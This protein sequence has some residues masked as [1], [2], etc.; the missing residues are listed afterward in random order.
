MNPR[1]GQQIV[2]LE[3]SWGSLILNIAY[4]AKKKKKKAENPLTWSLFSSNYA[5]L[6]NTFTALQNSHITSFT[7]KKTLLHTCNHPYISLKL[8][9]W[10]T[11]GGYSKCKSSSAN[12]L[13]L[14]FAQILSSQMWGPCAQK[15]W[16]FPTAS[17]IPIKYIISTYK[18]CIL[19]L[20][21]CITARCQTY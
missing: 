3:L 11:E 1:F 7:E 14:K 8:L 20:N 18:F 2:F 15:L 9:C 12:V 4:G 10:L 13:S 19:H 21:N 16:L 6:Q 5:C 17:A